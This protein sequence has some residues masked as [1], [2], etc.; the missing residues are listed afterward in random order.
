MR[1]PRP[2]PMDIP[3]PTAAVVGGQV[4]IPNGLVPNLSCPYPG[5]CIILQP[6]CLCLW[7]VCL[8]GQPAQMG[9]EWERG[10]RRQD[11]GGLGDPLEKL[12]KLQ[13]LKLPMDFSGT[14]ANIFLCS[15]GLS[16]SPITCAT[17][18][19]TVYREGC[20]HGVQEAHVS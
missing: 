8:R 9:Q 20:T 3:L 15:V 7:A 14:A 18:L 12:W 10:D 6:C 13:K 5:R 11:P 4:C 2:K 16:Q 1:H 17:P 19:V